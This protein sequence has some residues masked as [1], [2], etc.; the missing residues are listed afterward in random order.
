MIGDEK[1][2]IDAFCSWLVENGWTVRR[3]EEF[4]DIVAERNEERLYA[5]AKGR[6]KSMGLDVDTLYGQ[7][8]RRMPT[9]EAKPKRFGIVVPLEGRNLA[10]RVPA[11]IRRMLDIEIFLVD[12]GGKVEQIGDA[13]PSGS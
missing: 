2:V 4:A 8:L 5:E 12:E 10:L 3:E 9:Q 1:R 6:T 11:R 7:L 13:T